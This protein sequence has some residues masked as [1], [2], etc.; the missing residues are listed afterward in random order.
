MPSIGSLQQCLQ[1]D[2]VMFQRRIQAKKCFQ[3]S[4]WSSEVNNRRLK[5]SVLRYVL[6]WHISHST[7]VHRLHVGT[8]YRALQRALERCYGEL[9]NVRG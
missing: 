7:F 3:C 9:K 2:T 4:S 6:S 5:Y 1:W 8:G